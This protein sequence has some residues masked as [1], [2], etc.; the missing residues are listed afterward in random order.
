MKSF[1]ATVATLRQQLGEKVTPHPVCE[2][3][4]QVP[5]KDWRIHRATCPVIQASRQPARSI[6]PSP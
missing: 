2:C 3:G 5:V 1:A 6:E 4:E